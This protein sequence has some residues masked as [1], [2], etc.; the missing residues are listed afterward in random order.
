MRKAE[1]KRKTKE[2][3]ILVKLN[4]DGKGKS[5]V[6]T[7]IAFF[8]H[9][10]DLF[11]KHGLFDLEIKAKG[12]LAVDM[13]HTIEDIGICLGQAV[14]KAL[15]K[16]L[17]IRRFGSSAVPMDETLSGVSIDISNRPF[18]VFNI[19]AKAG[20]KEAFDVGLTREF[21]RAFC[22]NAGI[23]MHVNLPYG[24]DAHHINEAIFKSLSIALKQAVS[25]EK[26]RKGI[27]STKGRL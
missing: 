11:T 24:Q 13:H 21:L 9:M 6:S 26:R 12:D 19:K 15:G 23:T 10:L 20:A 3:D 27:P 1:I 18:L 8:D 5:K 2:T 7:G 4:L 22:N 17:G 14:K 25:T 16:K